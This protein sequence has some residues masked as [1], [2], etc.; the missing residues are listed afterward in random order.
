M[1]TSGLPK[2][3]FR[4]HGCE[5]RHHLAFSNGSLQ[6]GVADPERF[7]SDPD[8]TFYADADPNSYPNFLASKS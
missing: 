3:P 7:D 4:Q 8:P 1:E 5:P 2:I 6:R